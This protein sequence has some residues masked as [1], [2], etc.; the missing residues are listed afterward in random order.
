VNQNRE[1]GF[2]LLIVLWTLVLISFLVAQLSGAARTE[3]RISDNL[4][5]NAATQVAADGG[6]YAA[7]F[8]RLDPRHDLRW[9]IRASTGL[10]W[11]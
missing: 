11:G 3:I 10:A 7:I 5:A 2:A 8:N 6:I 4:A 9:I 1:T